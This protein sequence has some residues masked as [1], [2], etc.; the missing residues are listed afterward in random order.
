VSCINS[1][2]TRELRHEPW[3]SNS[4][5][6]TTRM[7]NTHGPTYLVARAIDITEWQSVD[8]VC[9][10]CLT[11]GVCVSHWTPPSSRNSAMELL[12][13]YHLSMPSPWLQCNVCWTSL[14]AACLYIIARPD[15]QF[16]CRHVYFF[17]VITHRS[18]VFQYYSVIWSTNTTHSRSPQTCLACA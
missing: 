15:S 12:E 1:K 5:M 17:F 11:H 6:A 4:S 13:C 16:L 14:G 7:E 9:L 10:C 18:T 8:T 3:Q 2:T